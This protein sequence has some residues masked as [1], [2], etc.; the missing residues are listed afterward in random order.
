MF[1]AEDEF[2]EIGI[3][4][5]ETCSLE[6]AHP[7][8]TF[9]LVALPPRGRPQRPWW[10]KTEPGA[11]A[12]QDPTGLRQAMRRAFA[13]DWPLAFRDVANAVRN[14]YGSVSQ[15][16]LHR[17]VRLF[18]EVER[19]IEELDLGLACRIYIRSSSKRKND[20]DDLREYIVGRRAGASLIQTSGVSFLP[21]LRGY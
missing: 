9:S 5:D 3:C 10:T 19:F 17:C 13:T 11:Y 20:I 4:R 6:Y 8:H 21:S 2:A 1:D 12:R 18:I 7:S 16:T 15:R 14:D